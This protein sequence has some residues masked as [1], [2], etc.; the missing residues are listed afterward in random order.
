MRIAA[1]EMAHSLSDHSP[2]LSPSHTQ[3]DTHTQSVKHTQTLQAGFIVWLFAVFVPH[4]RSVVQYFLSPDGSLS[5]R[6]L[7]PDSPDVPPNEFY[8]YIKLE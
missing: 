7:S 8:A 1:S 4:F 6:R 2:P 3:T 5:D